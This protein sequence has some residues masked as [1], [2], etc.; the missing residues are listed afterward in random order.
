MFVLFTD[1]ICPL[2]SPTSRSRLLLRGA[3]PGDAAPCLD[4]RREKATT[5]ASCVRRMQVIISLPPLIGRASPPR[6]MT[7]VTLTLSIGGS[8][9]EGTRTPAG[10]SSRIQARHPPGGRPIPVAWNR[11]AQETRPTSR[12]A[13]HWARRRTTRAEADIADGRFVTGGTAP[14]RPCA[15]ALLARRVTGA[16]AIATWCRVC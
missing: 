4:S 5:V 1:L 10:A 2:P 3:V 11:R 12:R 9:P 16:L 8:T 6:E 14:T 15:P 7:A 13:P